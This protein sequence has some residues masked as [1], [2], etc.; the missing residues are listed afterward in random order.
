M[1]PLLFLVIFLSSAVC[2]MVVPVFAEP[3][4]V[5]VR[6]NVN[7]SGLMDGSD[8]ALLVAYL[9]NPSDQKPTL[10]CPDEANVNG[11]GIIDGGDLALFV[12]YLTSTPLTK[13]ELPP[14]PSHSAEVVHLGTCKSHMAQAFQDSVENCLE[15]SY[16]GSA[17]LELVHVNALFNCCPDSATVDIAI[18][19]DTVTL[20][21][22]EHVEHPCT[23]WC[24]YDLGIRLY[25]MVPQIYRIRIKEPLR[26]PEE[27]MAVD[28]DLSE[29]P[30][31]RYCFWVEKRI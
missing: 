6:G 25:G 1:K 10:P 30:S 8:L 2:L 14:C 20:T 17:V 9:T 11:S 16:D 19:G 15:W 18:S 21:E 4:C 23:C 7:M 13:P 24:E 3:C 26:P 31:G 29:S 22:K 5:G 12:T 28:I 27:W